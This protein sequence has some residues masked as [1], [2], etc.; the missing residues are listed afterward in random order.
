VG[1]R[2]LI[3]VPLYTLSKYS[4][5]GA[6]PATLRR[7]GLVRS[8]NVTDDFGDVSIRPL[9]GDVIEGR[10]KNFTHF[11]ESS[12]GVYNVARGVEA[13]S[14]IVL[15]GECSE[16]VGI[17][18]GLAE[19][20]GGR[21]GMLWMDAHG[22]FN[23]PET[24]P[25]GYIGGMCLAMA[26]GRGPRSGLGPSEA[27]LT[28]ER[29]VHMGSRALDPPEEQAFASSPVKLVTARE[30]KKIGAAGAA[31]SAVRYLEENSD[32]IAC[33]LDVDVMDPTQIP[34]VN[35]PTPGGITVEEASTVLKTLVRSDKMRLLEVAAYNSSLDREGTSL[36][37]I[38][39]A[40]EKAFH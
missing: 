3:G 13:D 28:D 31:K 19:R 2:A 4:G 1:S 21:P 17:M 29:L 26:A 25:S 23:T 15:G 10:V 7:A 22:D 38:A 36:R 18:A 16:T 11:K 30:L 34:A 8:L 32:W 6:A 5:M 39:E 9:L 40:L 33:H 35:Y 24:S 27:P 14:V 20:F 37:K 12:L